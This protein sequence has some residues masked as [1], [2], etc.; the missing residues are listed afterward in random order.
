MI[1]RLPLVNA[2]LNSIAFVLLMMGWRAVKTGRVERHKSLMKAA[3]ATSALFLVSY[4]TYHYTKGHTTFQHQGWK[5]T[6]Y[7]TILIT[8]VPLA[9]LMVPPI[10]ALLYFAWKD[11]IAAHRRLARWTLPVWLYVSVTGVMIYIMNFV[12]WPSHSAP[13]AG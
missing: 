9:G 1:E 2:I 13:A 8:H 3:F 6:V 5:R 4:L 10:L 7:F 11:R 12:L